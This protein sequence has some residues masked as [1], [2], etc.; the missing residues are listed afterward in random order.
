MLADSVRNVAVT[1]PAVWMIARPSPSA[2]WHSGRSSLSVHDEV[3][4]GRNRDPAA[5]GDRGESQPARVADRDRPV[6][7]VAVRLVTA[8]FVRLIPVVAARV[9]LARVTVPP[10]WLIAPPSPATWRSRRSPRSVHD[11]FPRGRDRG[12]PFGLEIVFRLSEPTFEIV[13][14][15]AEVEG[16]RL[17]MRRQRRRD[18]IGVSTSAP[19]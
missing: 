9:R 5:N 12:G 1:V 3:P 10:V 15:P 17:P 11:E 4:R 13:R 8:M 2:T 19:P 7:L 18:L 16:V 14:L 6:V